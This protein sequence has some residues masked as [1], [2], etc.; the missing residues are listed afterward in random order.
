[1]ARKQPRANVEPEEE[2]A[3][4]E[5]FQAGDV[6]ELT[7]SAIRTWAVND[8][9][10]KELYKMGHE[11][12]FLVL[13]TFPSD[14]HGPCV[15]LFP[16]CHRFVDRKAVHH[17]LRCKGHPSRYF[18]KVDVKRLP[19]KG[20]KSAALKLPFLPWDVAAVDYEEDGEN[21]K[22]SVSLLGQ[23]GSI[24]GPWAKFLKN[25]AENQNLL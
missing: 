2:E 15:T 19:Q 23:K 4:G 3:S 22:L 8:M 11:N 21:P 7:P 16:C 20:D 9:T 25:M 24:S 13:D 10:P 5:T 18:K 14:E 6:V 17:K 12:R 1:M